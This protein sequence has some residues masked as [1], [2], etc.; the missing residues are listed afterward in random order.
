MAVSITALKS[1]AAAGV[2]SPSAISRPPVASAGAR[3]V[4]EPVA[5]AEPDRLE[6]LAGPLGPVPAEPAEQLLDAVA[7]E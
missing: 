3:G 5:R 7:D 4:G 1:A 6:E 2:S